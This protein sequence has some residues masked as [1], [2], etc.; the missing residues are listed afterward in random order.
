MEINAGKTIP[1]VL[2]V[3]DEGDICYLL[4]SLLK[5]KQVRYDHVNTLSQAVIALK[6]ETPSLVFLD[7]RLPDGKGINFIDHIKSN[8]P[9]VKIVII[10]AHDNNSDKETAMKKG[11]DFFIAKPFTRKQI[12][13]TLEQLTDFA[14]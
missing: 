8:Y 4:S 10:T 3:D 11:A 1:F 5:Q 12:Y 2:I 6:E 9:E 13:D 7:N 14:V